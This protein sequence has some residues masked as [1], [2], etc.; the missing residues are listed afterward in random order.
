VALAFEG[1]DVGGAV[2]EPAVVADDHGA[3]GEVL[4]RGF[5]GLEG[6]DVEFVGRFVEQDDVAA[7]GQGLGQVDA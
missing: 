7:A 5:E 2:E 1:E 3:A 4:E 6:F